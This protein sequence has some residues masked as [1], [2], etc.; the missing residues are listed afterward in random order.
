MA[1]NF[2]RKLLFED[3]GRPYNNKDFEEL[4]K[5]VTNI[6]KIFDQFTAGSLTENK[7]VLEG[8]DVQGQ[9]G[10][11]YLNGE[12]RYVP[13]LDSVANGPVQTYF[14]NV[15][16]NGE[17]ENRIYSDENEKPAFQVFKA[18]WSATP[19]ATVDEY[20]Q[21][22]TVA[23]YTNNKFDENAYV[24]SLEGLKGAIDLIGGNGI[25]ISPNLTNKTITITAPVASGGDI[26]FGGTGNPANAIAKFTDATTIIDTN[27][28]H[29]GNDFTITGGNFNV[30]GDKNIF[31]GSSTQFL[32]LNYSTSNIASILASNN[33]AAAVLNI[34]QGTLSNNSLSFATNGNAT[35]GYNVS[36]V[37]VSG[38][39]AGSFASLSISGAASVGSLSTASATITNLTSTALQTS[40]FLTTSTSEF[41]NRIIV[42]YSAAGGDG[43]WDNSGIIIKNNN[44]AP[45]EVAVSFQSSATGSNYWF[46]GMNQDNVF[47]WAYGTTYTNTLRKMYLTDTGALTITGNGT[48]PDWI[49]TSDE[50]L[51]YNVIPLPSQLN[52]VAE[53]G[54]LAVKY[55]RLD[56]KK[57]REEIGFVAQQV[58]EHYP[59]FVHEDASEEKM[60]SLSYSKMVAPLYKAIS[61]LKDIVE[62]Q[63]QEIDKLKK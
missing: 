28:S 63:Q 29:S 53:V 21:F 44:A 2:S 37:N 26:S 27:M 61:E 45:A 8:C 11:V 57:K 9:A 23:D 35:F 43:T 36:A 56:D 42:D 19:A 32:G 59:E 52:K 25:T 41:R 48:A 50:R 34:K 39:A 5:R 16:T 7:F 6:N 58:R 62:K 13:F 12:V 10:Y 22:Q 38:S 33:T 1:D 55:Q 40:T 49:A 47:S 60:L 24:S 20:I 3:G 17:I 18:M 4:Q 15:D 30:A 46:T 51:K 31:V 14:V 54:K